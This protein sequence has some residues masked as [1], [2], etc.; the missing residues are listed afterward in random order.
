MPCR[1]TQLNE[2]RLLVELEGDATELINL[3][4]RLVNSGAV[5]LHH[6]E[7]YSRNPQEMK[8]SLEDDLETVD[9]SERIEQ[10]KRLPTHIKQC[11]MV[12]ITRS[13]EDAIWVKMSI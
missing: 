1:V 8:S 4:K 13:E 9:L 12:Y 3:H 7:P 10:L 11:Q 2:D 5:L 6:R